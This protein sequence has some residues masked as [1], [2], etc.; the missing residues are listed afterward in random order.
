VDR[1]S[2][3]LVGPQRSE[4]GFRIGEF[5]SRERALE[6]AELIALDLSIESKWSGWAV[7]VRDFHGRQLF[8]IPVLQAAAA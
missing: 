6:L 7:E 1:Y 2:F 5:P 4:L 8:T 3:A